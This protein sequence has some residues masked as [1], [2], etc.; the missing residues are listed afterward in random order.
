M[1][2][3]LFSLSCVSFVLLCLAG[4]EASAQ[5]PIPGSYSVSG[6]SAMNRLVIDDPNCRACCK[7]SCREK[8]YRKFG[9]DYDFRC[10]GIGSDPQVGCP[11]Q[12]SGR[13]Q[14]KYGFKWR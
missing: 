3:K 1:N 12:R 4:S 6:Y 2:Q 10:S 14:P 11:G 9:S 5:A 7:E 13:H 8:Y